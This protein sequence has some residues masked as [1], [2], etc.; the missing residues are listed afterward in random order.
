MKRDESRRKRIPDETRMD[1]DD[2][3]PINEEVDSS[4]PEEG[5]P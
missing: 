2:E 1:R 5:S 4:G 3:T